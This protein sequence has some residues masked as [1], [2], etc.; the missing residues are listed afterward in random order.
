MSV[1]RAQSI[2]AR[3]AESPLVE[4]FVVDGLAHGRSYGLGSCSYDIRLAKG[5]L[6]QQGFGRLGVCIEKIWMPTDLRG[7]I[8]NKSTNARMFVNASQATNIEPGWFGH[9]T[10]EITRHRFYPIY[11]RAGTP[12]A[13]VVFEELDGHTD[14]PYRGKYQG[15]PAR[16][17]RAILERAF[18]EEV[19]RS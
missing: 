1:L 14:R 2:L 5:L 11:I 19:P 15:Q 7:R 17:V 6:V 18:S 16:P 12:I 10:V 9:L 8:E 3:H 4:P 13:T